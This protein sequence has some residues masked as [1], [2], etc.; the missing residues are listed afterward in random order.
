[1][2][3]INGFPNQY[4]GWGSE[5]DDIRVRSGDIYFHIHSL[6]RRCCCG[7]GWLI[8]W[9]LACVRACY[10]FVACFALA[11][12]LALALFWGSSLAVGVG[13]WKVGVPGGDLLLVWGGGKGCYW[14]SK[15]RGP[16]SGVL[17]GVRSSKR[18]LVPFS[19]HFLSHWKAL[20]AFKVLK[21]Q[22]PKGPWSI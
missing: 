13:G 2:E 6:T 22:F 19:N 15:V 4:F 5:K 3:L 1:M 20:R 17:G 16:W 21:G 12:A 9:L 8:G 18:G 10:C 14:D 7:V 11:L